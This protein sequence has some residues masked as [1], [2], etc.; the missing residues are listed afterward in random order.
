MSTQQEEIE[1]I[2]DRYVALV[3]C[4][5][6]VSEEKVREDLLQMKAN[7]F[8]YAATDSTAINSLFIQVW[9]FF[10]LLLTDHF[11]IG[12]QVD[13]LNEKFDTFNEQMK[14]AI[15]HLGTLIS[16]GKP[17]ESEKKKPETLG[18]YV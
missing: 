1:E 6:D 9:K 18:Q 8:H 3:A 10:L 5:N 14:E 15:Q 17:D 7:F 11:Y 2:E 4:V 12:N 13:K 16:G